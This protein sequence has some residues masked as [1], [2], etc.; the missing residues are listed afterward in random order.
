MKTIIF[1][2]E[3]TALPEAVLRDQYTVPA[4]EE[5]SVGNAT[6]PETI[7]RK[8][9][10]GRER[11]WRNY[12]EKA[13]LNA[14]TA[15]VRMAGFLTV[16]HA[17]TAT[18]QGRLSAADEHEFDIFAWDEAPERRSAM[19]VISGCFDSERMVVASAIKTVQQAIAADINIITYN[20]EDFDLPFL[21]RRAMFLGVPFN[22]TQLR[23]GRWWNC[24]FIDLRTEIQLGQREYKTGG[25]SGLAKM[26]GCTRKKT[27]GVD[28]AKFGE[29]FEKD[30]ALA[31]QYL[32]DDLLL[33]EEVALRMG[34]AP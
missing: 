10:E 5:I 22:R 4:D 1:D 12:V 18:E 7:E 11:H 25:L 32:R 30:P 15:Q 16:T 33:T 29:T 31:V 23:H 26:L 34:V 21:L 14:A 17:G 28:G 19:G 24:A 6:K 8:L 13:A 2:I 9:A 20:G 3:T 27:D